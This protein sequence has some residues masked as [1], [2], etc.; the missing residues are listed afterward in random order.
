M[1]AIVF[2]VVISISSNNGQTY[3]KCKTNN[4]EWWN[5]TMQT[6]IPHEI[7]DTIWVCK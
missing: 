4:N 5:W 7:G 3:Y 1:K 2:W 6:P